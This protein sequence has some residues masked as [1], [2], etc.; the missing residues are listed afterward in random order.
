MRN[1]SFYL[2]VLFTMLFVGLAL[3]SPDDPQQQRTVVLPEIP[4]LPLIKEGPNRSHR[5]RYRLI[6]TRA[7][8]QPFVTTKPEELGQA[9]SL[10]RTIVEDHGGELWADTAGGQSFVV[11]FPLPI[12]KS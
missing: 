8:M 11:H 2:V 5:C 1:V 4:P 6:S 12:S 7:R 3:W 9:L 10:R